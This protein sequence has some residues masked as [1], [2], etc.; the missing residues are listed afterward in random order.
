MGRLD[1]ERHQGPMP[2]KLTYAWAWPAFHDEAHM[3]AIYI[4][5]YIIGTDYSV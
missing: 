3:Q 5:I 2:R 4:Y 1:P